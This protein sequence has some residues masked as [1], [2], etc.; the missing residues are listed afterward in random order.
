MRDDEMSVAV[1]AAGVRV[2]RGPATTSPI[3]DTV[4]YAIVRRA[5]DDRPGAWCHAVAT[6]GTLGYI[7]D[8][9]VSPIIISMMGELERRTD[10]WKI[11]TI[12]YAGD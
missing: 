9:Y 11:V 1:V 6:D 12:G 3:L 7:D 5:D 4:S 10:G 8:Q 2:R